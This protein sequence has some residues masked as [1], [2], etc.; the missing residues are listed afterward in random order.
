MRRAFVL[1][2]MKARR[3]YPGNRDRFCNP[4]RC[5]RRGGVA[6]ANASSDGRA[7]ASN[8]FLDIP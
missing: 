5:N 2:G 8:K 7:A 6:R 3:Y 1:A 4:G